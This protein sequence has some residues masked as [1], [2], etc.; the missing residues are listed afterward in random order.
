MRE[1]TRQERELAFIEEA[2]NIHEKK[3]S[4]EKI[5]YINCDTNVDI[6]C[7]EHGIFKQTPYQHLC[8]QGCSKCHFA[9]LSAL[10]S[11]GKQ[12]FIN[13]CIVMHDNKYD[14]SQVIYINNKEEVK[15][16]CPLH[17]IFEQVADVHMRG[18]GCSKCTGLAKLTKEDFIKKAI[19][20]HNNRYDYS[21]VEYYN[22]RTKIKIKCPDLWPF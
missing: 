19:V 2:K 10:F 6:I 18:F 16:I 3:Y 15:I 8:G 12:E 11:M 7:E 9:K 21:E 5:H 22:S 17:G 1:D 14:Y 20:V 13:K 4:Y